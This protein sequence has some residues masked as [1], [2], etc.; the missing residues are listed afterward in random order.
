MLPAFWWF[1]ATLLSVVAIYYFWGR[2]RPAKENA[3]Q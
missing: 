1:L 3:K 2:S